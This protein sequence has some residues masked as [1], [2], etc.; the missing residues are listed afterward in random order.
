[1]H[2]NL[3]IFNDEYDKVYTQHGGINTEMKNA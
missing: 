1:L 3:T 2:S